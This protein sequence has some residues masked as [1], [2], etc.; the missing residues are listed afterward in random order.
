MIVVSALIA[1]LLI[2]FFIGLWACIIVQADF[3]SYYDK[4]YP[5]WTDW[6]DLNEDEVD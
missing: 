1:G 2:G 5:N 4:D 6:A 3:S